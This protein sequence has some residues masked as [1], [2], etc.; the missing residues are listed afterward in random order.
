MSASSAIF[1]GSAEAEKFR[2]TGDN[3][4]GISLNGANQVGITLNHNNNY[5]FAATE[6]YTSNS[7][8]IINE[9]SSDTNPIFSPK[10]AYDDGLGGDTGKAVLI[11]NSLPRVVAYDSGVEF[12]TAN[13]KISGSSS[14]TGSF[15][16]GYIDNKL[17]IGTTAPAG[18]L[19]VNNAGGSSTIFVDKA[20]FF[21]IIDQNS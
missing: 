15:G 6:F 20:I 11:T 18:Q 16:A 4:T 19:H 9:A 14:S 10:G 21:Y 5:V 13:G 17:G 12:P 8:R 2:F 1:S 3:D 7:N